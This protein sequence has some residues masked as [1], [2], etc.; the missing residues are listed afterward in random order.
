MPHQGARRDARTSPSLRIAAAPVVGQEPAG[1]EPSMLCAP[2][3]PRALEHPAPSR[4]RVRAK[5]ISVDRETLLEKG[6]TCGTLR[7]VEHGDECPPS[8]IVERDTADMSA[9]G[10]NAVRTYTTPPERVLEA[11]FQRIGI[12]EADPPPIAELELVQARQIRTR[13]R[14]IDRLRESRERTRRAHE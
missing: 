11:A 14:R 12:D 2:P 10:V 8:A 4:P 3:P 13:E 1:A 9:N 6:V 7:P 5:L